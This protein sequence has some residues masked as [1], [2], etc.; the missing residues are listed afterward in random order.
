MFQHKWPNS[1]LTGFGKQA[2]VL[3]AIVAF[4]WIAFALLSIIMTTLLM[5]YAALGFAP[6]PAHGLAATSGAATGPAY[7]MNARE[8]PAAES[9]V[10]GPI[11]A[12]AAAPIAAAPAAPVTV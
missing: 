9:P 7:G 11:P 5:H 2:H 12:T 6:A 3:N 4:G 8:K 10:A 1:T